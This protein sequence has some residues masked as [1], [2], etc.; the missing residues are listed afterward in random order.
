MIMH[1]QAVNDEPIHFPS[2]FGTS[3]RFADLRIPTG[4][5]FR[6]RVY[7]APMPP[8]VRLRERAAGT[9]MPRSATDHSAVA[10]RTKNS[11]LVA[12]SLAMGWKAVWRVLVAESAPTTLTPNLR[13]G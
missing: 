2:T 1:Q 11:Q 12:S 9:K 7:E 5:A 8:T 4:S 6:L 13:V 10:G 3:Y